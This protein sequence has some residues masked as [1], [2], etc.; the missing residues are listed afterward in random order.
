VILAIGRASGEVVPLLFTGA[1]VATQGSLALN[2][3]FMDLAYQ[4]FVLSTQSPDPQASR[5]L[6]LAS[7]WALV[8]LSLL[9]NAGAAILRS[10]ATPAAPD[11]L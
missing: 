10:R 8:F 9:L 2:E 3:R 7:V 6:L 4:V 11:R 1:A 5:P